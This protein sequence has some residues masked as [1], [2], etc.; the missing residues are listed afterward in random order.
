MHLQKGDPFSGY[1]HA[2]ELAIVFL[3]LFFTGPGRYSVDYNFGKYPSN[4]PYVT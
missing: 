2:L 1:S 4:S 3:S